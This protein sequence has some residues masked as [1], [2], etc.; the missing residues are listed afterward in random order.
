LAVA[1]QVTT[2]V[3]SIC[4]AAELEKCKELP[5]PPGPL[6][7]ENYRRAQLNPDQYGKDKND[8]QK[9]DERKQCTYKV[10]LSL[11]KPSVK[12]RMS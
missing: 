8:R 4:H 7:P 12:H 6:L 9:N 11:S 1:K 5:V 2:G 10:E 3:P